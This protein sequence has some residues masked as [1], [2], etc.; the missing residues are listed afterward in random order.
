MTDGDDSARYGAQ[1]SS[2]AQTGLPLAFNADYDDLGATVKGI[3]DDAG[4]ALSGT[5]SGMMPT[6]TPAV[7]LVGIGIPGLLLAGRGAWLRRRS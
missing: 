7:P 4:D 1:T 3:V 5:D 2:A 6:P